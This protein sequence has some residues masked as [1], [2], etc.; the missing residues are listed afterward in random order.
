MPLGLAFGAVTYGDTDKHI[1]VASGY[2]YEDV[3]FTQ[4]GAIPL[5]VA[6]HQRFTERTALITE[7]WMLFD[8][9]PQQNANTFV[10][11]ITSI[12]FRVIGKRDRSSRKRGALVT[13]SGYP[14]STWDFGLVGVFYPERQSLS[15]PITGEQVFS[16]F[17]DV[18]GFGPMPWIDYTWHFGPA[19]K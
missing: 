3:G 15:D 11:G 5:M 10:A 4:S 14:R 1:T 6:G 8:P 16:E 2:A 13:K 7:N 12:A 9:A 19:R 18:G 17:Q